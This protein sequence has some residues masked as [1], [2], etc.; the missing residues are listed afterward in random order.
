MGSHCM[1]LGVSIGDAMID[2]DLTVEWQTVF[3]HGTVASNF[4]SYWLP[5]TSDMI[6]LLKIWCRAKLFCRLAINSSI[7]LH[8]YSTKKTT[9]NFKSYLGVGVELFCARTNIVATQLTWVQ[10]PI[11]IF[12]EIWGLISYKSEL[13]A[14][15]FLRKKCWLKINVLSSK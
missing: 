9:H 6:L 1:M 14:S 15:M 2:D 8:S 3:I 13:S 10:L 5:R 7:T 12:V 4:A 11:P